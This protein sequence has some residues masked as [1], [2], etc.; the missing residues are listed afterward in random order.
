MDDIASDFR[1]G[2]VVVYVSMFLIT[3]VYEILP[4]K[5]SCFVLIED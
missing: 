5:W 3:L 4:T 2:H 1:T